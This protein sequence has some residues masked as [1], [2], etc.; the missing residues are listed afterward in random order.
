MTKTQQCQGYKA[1][2]YPP[3]NTRPPHTQFH[4]SR[5]K[6]KSILLKF[7]SLLEQQASEVAQILKDLKHE[8]VH[9]TINS[10]HCQYAEK[11]NSAIVSILQYA[12]RKTLGEAQF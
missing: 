3:P 5:L 10:E 8:L 9:G 2:D 11:A 6:D 7:A 12:A 1:P 4:S